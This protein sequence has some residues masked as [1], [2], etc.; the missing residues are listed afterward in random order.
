MIVP[1]ADPNYYEARPTIAIPRPGEDGGAIDLDGVVGLHPALAPLTPWYRQGALTVICG[2]GSLQPTRC[3]FRAQALL[4]RGVR[5]ATSTADGWLNRYLERTAD[6]GAARRRAAAIGRELPLAL[7]GG[8]PVGTIAPC[9]AVRKNSEKDSRY[10]PSPLG[11]AMQAIAWA[12]RREPNLEIAWTDSGGWDTHV[13]QGATSGPLAERLNDLAQ[14]IAAFAAD[15][16]EGMA[17]TV[18]LTMS[19]FGRTV[20]ENDLGGTDH[21]RGT[22]CLILGGGAC[23]GRVLGH[24][25]AIDPNV[26]DIAVTTDFRDVFA[27]LL[28]RHLGLPTSDVPTIF[29]GHNADRRRWVYVTT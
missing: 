2:V 18:V 29:P 7:R 4:E 1:Y 20:R 8:V 14:S 10:P 25:P 17:D 28:V 13:M 21:G 24:W 19:E 27:G 26:P 11:R 12:I 15:L 22:A 3:H 5:R 9:P 16:G 6:R 23:G